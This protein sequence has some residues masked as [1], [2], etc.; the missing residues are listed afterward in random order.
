MDLLIPKRGLHPLYRSLGT[1]IRTFF[2]MGW[3]LMIKEH[4]GTR[5]QI[6]M[7][8]ATEEGIGMIKALTDLMVDGQTKETTV[9]IFK[10]KTLP[11][12]RTISHPDVLSS[13]ILET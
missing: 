5:Q 13:L 10:E 6:I 9:H 2:N 4:A 1:D 8:L 12:F 3:D 7:K 11:F